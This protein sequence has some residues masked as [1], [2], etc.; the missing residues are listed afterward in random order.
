LYFHIGDSRVIIS[1][2]V[3]AVLWL[4][5]IFFQPSEIFSAIIRLYA[6]IQKMALI[7]LSHA[8]SV[9]CP[10]FTIPSIF[11]SFCFIGSGFS[12]RSCALVETE[13]L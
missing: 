1:Y 4:R 13:L 8:E 11:Y 9:F 3:E 12:T 6:Q 5:T 7:D 10:P 2:F